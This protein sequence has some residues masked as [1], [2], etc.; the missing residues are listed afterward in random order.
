MLDEINKWMLK[1][2]PQDPDSQLAKCTDYV[3]MVHNKFPF[4]TVVKGVVFS[5]HNIDNMGGTPKEYPHMWLET[6]SG[7]IIDPTENQFWLL[8]ELQYRKFPP[9]ASRSYCCIGCGNY[10]TNLESEFRPYHSKE[11]F[12]RWGM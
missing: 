2:I 12:E 7:E 8:G 1:N 3:P 4:L 9:N 6:P 11:C 10:Y 5:E